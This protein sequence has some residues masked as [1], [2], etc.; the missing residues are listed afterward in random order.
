MITHLQETWKIRNKVTY[1]YTIYYNY[2]LVDKLR[3]FNWSFNIKLSKIN[4]MDMQ[5]IEGYSRPEK[6]HE[7]AQHN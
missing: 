1:S 7:P 6:Y 3:F 4:R 2:F 5:K